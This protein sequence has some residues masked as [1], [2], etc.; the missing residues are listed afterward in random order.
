[1]VCFKARLT[2]CFQCYAFVWEFNGY[3]N[4]TC[5]RANHNNI[6]LTLRKVSFRFDGNSLVFS[7]LWVV[8]IFYKIDF[9]SINMDA[10]PFVSFSFVS[11]MIYTFL[12]KNFQIFCWI[13][14]QVFICLLV[15]FPAVRNGIVYFRFLFW[16]VAIGL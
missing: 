2:L 13:C 12:H 7:L 5:F 8:C 15:C 9:L 14:F 11:P 3:L 10:F 16:W 4:L 1:M 6:F